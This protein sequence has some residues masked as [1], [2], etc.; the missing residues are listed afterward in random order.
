VDEK[1]GRFLGLVGLIGRYGLEPIQKCAGHQG[2][3]KNLQKFFSPF[4]ARSLDKREGRAWLFFSKQTR[5]SGQHRNK[6]MERQPGDRKGL[7][8]VG[9][10]GDGSGKF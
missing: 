6:L 10:R 5:T 9:G 8:Q 1:G 7:K 4:A 3:I 2:K